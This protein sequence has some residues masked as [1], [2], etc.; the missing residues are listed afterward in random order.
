[1]YISTGHGVQLIFTRVKSDVVDSVI[2][3][4]RSQQKTMS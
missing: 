3:E 4:V 2:D 1:M